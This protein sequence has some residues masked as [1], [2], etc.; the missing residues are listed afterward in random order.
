MNDRD[1][2][3]RRR[4]TPRERLKAIA[5]E[6]NAAG[7]DRVQEILLRQ[8]QTPGMPN[9]AKWQDALAEQKGTRKVHVRPDDIPTPKRITMA[10]DLAE[11]YGPE[12]D[13]AL[14]VEEPT[15]DMW[16]AGLIV[17]TREQ[18]HRLAMLTGWP[19][20]FFYMPE[21]V[22]VQGG[23]ICGDDGCQPLGRND[24]EPGQGE[25]F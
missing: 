9:T 6:Q 3:A 14:G 13:E 2:L 25:L 4:M 21:P 5:A 11:L 12:V 24:P 16:E 23:W 10:L 15:V 17:P 19:W 18:I 8:R 1:D 7:R 22:A 20:R